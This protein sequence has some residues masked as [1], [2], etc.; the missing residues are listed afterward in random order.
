MRTKVELDTAEDP[1]ARE[2]RRKLKDVQEKRRNESNDSMAIF[3]KMMGSMRTKVELD[4]AEDPEARMAMERDN[5]RIENARDIFKNMDASNGPEARQEMAAPLGEKHLRVEVKPDFLLEGQNKAEAIRKERLKEMASMKAARERAM[6]DEEMFSRQ[7]Q[8]RDNAMKRQREL[9]IDMMRLARQEALEEEER[10]E[11]LARSEHPRA[12]SPGLLAARNVQSSRDFVDQNQEKVERLR[13]ERAREMEEMRRARENMTE[14][15]YVV[16]NERSEATREL[17]AFRASRGGGGTIRDRYNPDTEPQQPAQSR[18]Q[19]FTKAPKMRA[20][21]GDN[22]MKNSSQEKA[23]AARVAR[24]REMEALMVARSHAIEEEEIER[25]QEEAER[26]RDA[27]RKAHEMAVL[28]ADLQ[29]MRSVTASGP[30]R[31][32]RGG[33]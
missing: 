24:E 11:S 10:L 32:L 33:V 22:W 14:E 12:L 28:V 18:S 19:T 29:K 6:E 2:E 1:E 31:R 9:E 4:T 30:R 13:L 23:E 5:A 21:A 17:E 27:E 7:N 20:K 26:R 3:R 16:S 15:D 8:N 25:A